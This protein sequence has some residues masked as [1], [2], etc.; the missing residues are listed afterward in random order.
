VY[1]GG[2]GTAEMGRVGG[3]KTHHGRKKLCRWKVVLKNTGDG[4]H[5]PT[6]RGEV[7]MKNKKGGTHRGNL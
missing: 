7:V 2:N 3:K 1:R 5:K 6:K 4:P